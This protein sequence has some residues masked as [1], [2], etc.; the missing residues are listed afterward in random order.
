[1]S[2]SAYQAPFFRFSNFNFPSPQEWGGRHEYPLNSE[3]IRGN[4]CMRS[5]PEDGNPRRPVNEFLG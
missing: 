4:I 3:L 5:R 1:M 2:V